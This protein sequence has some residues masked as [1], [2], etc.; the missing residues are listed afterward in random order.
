C[1]HLTQGAAQAFYNTL[2]VG[3]VVQVVR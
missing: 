1:V 2:H 3:D